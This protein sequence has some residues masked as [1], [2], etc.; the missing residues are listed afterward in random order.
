MRRRRFLE[1]SAAGVATTLAGCT[2]VSPPRNDSHPFADS[3]VTVRVDIDTESHHDLDRNAREALDFWEEHSSEYVGFE[4]A[5][6][7]AE[8]DPDLVIAYADDDRGCEGV[9]AS[10]ARV[11]GCAPILRP[12]S[13]PRR[14]V[15]AR[16]VAA[17]RPFGKIRITTK[18][19][20]GHVLGLGHDDDPRHIMSN[21]P[22]DRIPLYEERIEIWE[23]VL[24]S[25]THANGA[26]ERF[27]AGLGS[28]ENREYGDATERFREASD[29]YTA[30]RQGFVTARERTDIF[31]GN[32][33]VETVDLPAVRDH[34]DAL[35]EKTTIAQG[36]AGEMVD[37]AEQAD[38]GELDAANER[39]EAANEQIRE[40]NAVPSPQIRHVAV[41]LGLV[42]GFDRDDEIVEPTDTDVRDSFQPR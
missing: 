26:T 11:L 5:F 33:H 17:E 9:E 20:I 32:P 4:I 29:G 2:A 16:V 3:T 37:A 41:A 39:L 1:A 31:E 18:H 22:A 14:P 24:E 10:S 34:L 38:A 27:N 30:A 23:L 36:F 35:V 40:F 13:Q 8:A 12:G 19:E 21:Q 6:E 42:R 15:T 7:P 25:Q 28:W